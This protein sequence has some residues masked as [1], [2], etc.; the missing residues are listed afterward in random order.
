[1]D[2]IEFIA[3]IRHMCWCSYQLGAGQEFNEDINQD[4]LESLMQGV[5][6]QLANPGM[7]P[8]ESHENWMKMKASQEWVYSEVKD[9]ETHPDMVPFDK[10]PGVERAKDDMSIMSHV[11][12]TGLW[13]TLENNCILCHKRLDPLKYPIEDNYC[14]DSGTSRWV[15][16]ECY[17]K[18]LEGKNKG[19]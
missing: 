18:L 5:K 19:E 12:A 9:F 8:E 11:F 6:V 3:R 15:H 14:F 4:Q 2:K 13:D 16:K 10:L 7:T 17:D 1:M